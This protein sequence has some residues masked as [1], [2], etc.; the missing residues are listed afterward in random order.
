MN[1]GFTLIEIL[2]VIGIGLILLSLSLTVFVDSINYHAAEK[3]AD[4]VLSYIDKARNTAM[5]SND[6]SE[7]GVR[8]AS[9]SISIF[10][11]TTFSTA[12][13]TMVYNL[14]SRVNIFNIALSNGINDL[15][16]NKLTGKPNATGTITFKSVSG[17]TTKSLII[18]ST[19]L[20]EIQ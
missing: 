12:S 18:Y 3:D 13:T 11:G 10:Q 15:Y 1:K 6:F 19:G 14:S 20:S 16:F 17:S 8:F 9:T 5:N 7:Y 2:I 4:S